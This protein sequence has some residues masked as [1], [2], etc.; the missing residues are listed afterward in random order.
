MALAEIFA[1]RIGG[2][3]RQIARDWVLHFYAKGP[4]GLAYGEQLDAPL[5]FSTITSGR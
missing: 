1:T 5:A 3:G 4:D 2:V